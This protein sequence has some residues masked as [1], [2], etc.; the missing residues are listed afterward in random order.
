MSALSKGIS[1]QNFSR[2]NLMLTLIV[3][4]VVIA[5][6]FIPELIGF[7]RSLHGTSSTSRFE[8]KRVKVETREIP[9]S[10]PIAAVEPSQP[11]PLEAVSKLINSSATPP[12]TPLNG[13]PQSSSLPK[14]GNAPV[15][16]NLVAKCVANLTEPPQKKMEKNLS[17]IPLT[18]E[19]IQA[20]QSQQAMRTA[21]AEAL[22]IARQLNPKKT[23][24]RYAL[25]TYVNAIN[26]V[27]ASP[28]QFSS[29]EEAVNYIETVD[30]SVTKA[31][32]RE[33]SDRAD[34]LQWQKVSLG[35]ELQISRAS[36]LKTQ[37]RMPFNPRVSL[38]YVAVRQFDAD[39]T[40]PAYLDFRGYMYG[41]DIERVELYWKGELVSLLQLTEPDAKTGRRYF[42]YML[43][44]ARGLYTV[45]VYDQAGEKYSKS[46]EFFPHVTGYTRDGSGTYVVPYNAREIGEPDPRLDRI[47][48]SN[49][50]RG[51]SSSNSAFSTF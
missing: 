22:A 3:C 38:E 32:F 17:E 18:W 24:T 25:I 35:E 10:A 28:D 16:P 30:Q 7:Q 40:G 12:L 29:P 46:Y 14:E 13:A 26:A 1:V 2:S 31:I 15:D 4:L 36:R 34:Y 48:R 44:D 8:T 45:V 5:L 23:Q 19:R 20:P 43:A 11:S 27:L 6:F 37:Y 41:K 21:Q 47:F 49:G 33:G 39:Q 9:V 42:G 50:Q 51:E